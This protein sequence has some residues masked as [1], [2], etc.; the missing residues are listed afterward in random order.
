MTSQT[1][2]KSNDEMEAIIKEEKGID[3]DENYLGY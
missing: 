1:K 3:N 2:K